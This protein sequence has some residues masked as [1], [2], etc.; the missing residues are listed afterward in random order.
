MHLKCRYH[1]GEGGS[2]KSNVDWEARSLTET[3][4]GQRAAQ[5]ASFSA[6]RLLPQDKCNSAFGGRACT[7][8]VRGRAQLTPSAVEPGALRCAGT[9][10]HE[11]LALSAA[12]RRLGAW[13]PQGPVP[14]VPSWRSALGSIIH[15]SAPAGFPHHANHEAPDT[16]SPQPPC[17]ASAVPKACF[18]AATS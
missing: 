7:P 18:D 6:R 16:A 1:P 2:E 3:M 12:R 17:G 9:A 11:K 13:R 5:H 4:E 10:I 8:L 15:R 14:A